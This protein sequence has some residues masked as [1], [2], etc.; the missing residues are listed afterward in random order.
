MTAPEYYFDFAAATPLDERVF[1]VMRP[2]FTERFFNPSSPY[3]PAVQVRREYQEAKESIARHIGAHADEI[4]M[5]AGATE[6]INLALRSSEGRVAYAAIEHDSVRQ[7][8]RSA[9]G[10][11]EIEV[12]VSGRVAP[13][14]VR[15][16]ITDDVSIVSVALANHELG[17][18]QPI[19]SIARMIA[20]ERERRLLTNNRLP[21]LL[22]CDGSQGLGFLDI[23]VARLG[24]DLLTLN[25]AKVYGP[26]QVGLLWVKPGVRLRPVTYGGG[27]ELGLRS[28]TENVAGVIGFAKAMRLAE[29][30]RKEE[31]MRLANLRDGMQRALTDALPLAIISGSQKHRLANFLHISFPGIDAE[32]LIFQLETQGVYVATGSACAANKGTGSTVLAAIGLD[33]Q[34]RQG[35]IR[36]S[37]GRTTTKQHC[38]YAVQ[39][40]CSAVNQELTRQGKHG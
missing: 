21:L 40:I 1:D 18:V 24:V 16:A 20:E 3:E 25:A 37:L 27:Q 4:I 14:A 22:H 34:A 8:A 39:A 15:A 5:C 9:Q 2:Y 28:G 17:T 30:K 38:E 26:K 19:A 36:L 11:A 23:H 31:T 33:Q 35:S 13:E 32:R 7:A 29:K 12:G 6:S 10:Y